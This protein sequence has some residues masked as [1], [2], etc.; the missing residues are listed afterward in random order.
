MNP[1]LIRVSP[2]CAS[3]TRRSRV[4][5]IFLVPPVPPILADLGLIKYLARAELY[6]ARAGQRLARELLL[7]G[8]LPIASWRDQYDQCVW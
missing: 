6:F 2:T 8:K 1:P 7:F 3:Y 5:Q 4:D